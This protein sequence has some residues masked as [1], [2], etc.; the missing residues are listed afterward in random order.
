MSQKTHYPAGA[1]TEVLT[2]NVSAHSL[3]GYDR[4]FSDDDDAGYLGVTGEYDQLSGDTVSLY[5]RGIVLIATSGTGSAG[6]ALICAANG[7]VK[8][9]DG[10]EFVVGYALDDFV[11]ASYVRVKLA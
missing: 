10:S 8:A 3:V 6:N 2:G 4:K 5:T 7:K 11:N 9:Q 1:I